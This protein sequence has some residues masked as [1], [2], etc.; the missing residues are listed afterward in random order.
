MPPSGKCLRRIAPAAAKA[1]DFGCKTQNTN[2]KQKSIF[3][4]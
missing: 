2:K 3:F 1:I 4:S